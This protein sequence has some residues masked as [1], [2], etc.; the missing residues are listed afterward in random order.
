MLLFDSLFWW[1]LKHTTGVKC[2]F[3]MVPTIGVQILHLVTSVKFDFSFCWCSKFTAGPKCWFFMVFYAGVQILQL[4]TQVSSLDFSFCWC[5]KSA[6]GPKCQFLAVGV[7]GVQILWL[8]HNV[9]FWLFFHFVGV[10]IL[11]LAPN[12]GFLWPSMPVSH[13][14]SSFWRC[15]NF[16]TH[17]KC[18][19]VTIAWLGV[20]S[21]QF[22]IH[23]CFWQ[24]LC[25]GLE[26]TTREGPTAISTNLACR[27]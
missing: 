23:V 8:A 11:Q 5:S 12:V 4:D 13:F 1:C 3:L 18:W 27:N 25:W 16:T 6:A 22:I 17:T 9:K 24:L 10:Q 21:L 2:P 15:L 26:S 14:D 20:Q 19:I 7:L